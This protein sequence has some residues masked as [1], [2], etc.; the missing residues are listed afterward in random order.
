M[1]K[2]KLPTP[3]GLNDTRDNL[4][5]P[6]TAP[7]KFDRRTLRNT[8]RTLQYNVRVSQE[9]QDEIDAIQTHDR[10]TRWQ[11]LAVALEAY[12]ALPDAER[13]SLIRRVI[14]SDPAM[15]QFPT[16]KP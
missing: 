1:A 11:W 14:A 4:I 10:L 3:P 2:P 15:R 7:A 12:K 8:G 13:E 5:Q 6:E 9:F 16:S